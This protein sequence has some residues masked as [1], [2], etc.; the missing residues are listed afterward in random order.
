MTLARTA[1]AININ[2]GT[3]LIT[4]TASSTHPGAPKTASSPAATAWPNGTITIRVCD[5]GGSGT[6]RTPG[7]W[8]AT[9][10]AL[11]SNSL[12]VGSLSTPSKA[13]P[14][15]HQIQPGSSGRRA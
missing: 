5:T 12:T 7:N 10:M 9:G 6:E 15:A 13:R 11:V 4:I 8:V 2:I 3:R 14:I 1:C